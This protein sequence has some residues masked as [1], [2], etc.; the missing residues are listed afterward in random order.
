MSLV[1]RNKSLWTQLRH[2]VLG[3]IDS[4]D[5]GNGI[6][7][8]PAVTALALVTAYVLFAIGTRA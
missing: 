2:G 5:W 3:R 1:G 6:L 7:T 4:L 8:G